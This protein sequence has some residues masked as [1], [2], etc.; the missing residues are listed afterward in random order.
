MR[1]L[2]GMILG[3]LLAVAVVYVHDTMAA[4]AGTDGARVSTSRAIVNWGVARSEWG[5]VTESVHSAWLKLR[6]STTG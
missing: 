1:I 6:A 5:Q 2:F 4:P 3:C